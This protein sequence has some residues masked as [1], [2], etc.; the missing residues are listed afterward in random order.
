VLRSDLA[1]VKDLLAHGA[2]PNARITKGT[3]LRR[4][5]QDFNLPATLIGATPFWLAAKFVEP[6]IIRALLAGGAD[7]KLTI[8]DGTTPLMAAAG[9]K[10]PAARDADRRGL[11][12][13]DGGKL[14]DESVILD[15]VAAVLQ[16]GD[17]NAVNANGDTALHAAAAMG[18]D[19]V[20][21]LLAEKGAD[22]NIKNSRG[23][24]PL[25]ALLGRNRQASRTTPT[26]ELLRK[27][28]AAE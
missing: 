11:A 19:G 16:S 18:H 15:A 2:D 17:I 28:G 23:E 20:I 4:N 3:P 12:L 8:N 10:E 21:K 26:I 7:A 27:L 9:L 5:S 13:I 14:P 22:L 6:E 1:L 24:T 25:G